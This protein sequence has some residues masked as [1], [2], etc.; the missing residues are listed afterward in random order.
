MPLTT[1]DDVA[2]MLRWEAQEKAKHQQALEVYVNA[3]ESVVEDMIGP[4]IRRTFTHTA[5]GDGWSGVML[6]HSASSITKV[7]VDGVETTD[8]TANL[9]AGLIYAWFPHGRQNVTVTYTAGIVNPNANPELVPE[10][11]PAAIRL[12][13][14]MIAADKWAIASQRGPGFDDTPDPVYLTPRAVRDLLGAFTSGKTA[15]FA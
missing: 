15:G 11:L 2:T 10:D 5:D 3:A 7:E 12:A 13:S 4:V 14:T 6:P 1:V 8:Y 9:K